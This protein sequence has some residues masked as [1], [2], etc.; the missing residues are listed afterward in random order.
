[1][2][3]AGCLQFSNEFLNWLRE[4]KGLKKRS[5]NDVLSHLTRSSKFVDLFEDDLTGEDLAYLLSKNEEFNGLSP[6]VKSHLRRSVRLYYEFKFFFL[7]QNSLRL[8]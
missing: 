1:M 6:T 7:N 4:S 3:L 2:Q 5:S 8:F